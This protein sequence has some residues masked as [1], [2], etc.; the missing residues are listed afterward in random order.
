MEQELMGLIGKTIKSVEVKGHS[1]DC[2][3]KNV[4]AITMESGEVFY[5]IGGYGAWSHLI[6]VCDEYPE[7]ITIRKDVPEKVSG[8]GG[9]FDNEG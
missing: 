5:I 6:R 2:G 3:S 1:K 9:I 8:I 7:G 4:L